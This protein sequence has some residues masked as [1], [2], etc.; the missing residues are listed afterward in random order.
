MNDELLIKFLLNEATVAEK[1]QVQEWIAASAENEKYYQQF[2]RI[3]NESAELTKVAEVDEEAAWQKFRQRVDEKQPA[4]LV[5]KKLKPSRIW[6]Q[7]AAVF[8]IC[9]GT[10]LAYQQFGG[11]YTNLSSHDLVLN[12]KLPDGSE[13]V[14]NK[15]TSISYATDFKTNRKVQI[16]TGEVFFDVAKDRSHPFII[17]IN[18]VKVEVVG[19]SFNIKKLNSTV[20]VIVESGIVKVSRGEQQL[21]LTK[22]ER[23]FLSDEKKLVKKQTE[24]ELYNYYRTGIFVA[25]NTPLP[26]LVKV[27]SEAYGIKISLSE[28]AKKDSIFTTLPLKYSLEKNLENI[29]KG[30]DLK[31]QRNQDEI[32]LSKK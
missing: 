21:T 7:V 11:R 15:N 27:L 30:L 6:M 8:V 20:E 23:V 22:G 26:K 19:T 5:V 13:L 28:A 1:V 24:D 32:L 2:E 9:F 31:M 16:E 25:Q 17:D 29:C 4:V 3:W 12:Q 10:W 18:D 14:L